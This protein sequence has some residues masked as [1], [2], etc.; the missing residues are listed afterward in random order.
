MRYFTT[1]GIGP[2]TLPKDV[3]VI[4]VTEGQN[5][6]GTWGDWLEVSRPLTGAE[7]FQYDIREVEIV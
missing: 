3:E 7:L 1:H 6:K 4:K 2:G 5:S